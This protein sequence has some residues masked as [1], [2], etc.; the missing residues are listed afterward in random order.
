MSAMERRALIMQQTPKVV[1][2]G[3]SDSRVPIEIVF[4]QGLGDIFAVR[5][6]GNVLSP[7]TNGSIDYAV[8]HLKVKLVLVMGH[9]GCGAVKAAQLPDEKISKES[10]AL[11]DLLMGMKHELCTSRR[12]LDIRDQRARDREAV[13][14]NVAAQMRRILELPHIQERVKEGTLLVVGAF[15]EITSGM[16]DFFEPEHVI[17]N[18][19]KTPLSFADSKFTGQSPSTPGRRAVETP[20]PAKELKLEPS[21]MLPPTQAPADA[22]PAARRTSLHYNEPLKVLNRRSFEDNSNAPEPNE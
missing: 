3:C 7:G 1:V 12:I 14:T 22:Y 16:V 8:A 11:R 6:A 10:P 19:D 18:L 17:P 13:V 9:E 21:M 5:V 20:P 15:Y 2:L 4:D